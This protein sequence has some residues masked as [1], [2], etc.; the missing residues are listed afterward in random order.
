MSPYTAPSTNASLFRTF[1][2]PPTAVTFNERPRAVGRGGG[3]LNTPSRAPST[4]STPERMPPSMS[5]LDDT[6][7]STSMLPVHSRSTPASVAHTPTS[8]ASTAGLEPRVNVFGF[9]P[10]HEARVLREIRRHGDVV[11]FEVER[12]NWTHAMY[13]TQVSAQVLLYRRGHYLPGNTV[14]FG[15]VSFTEPEIACKG[16]RKVVSTRFHWVRNPVFESAPKLD[17]NVRL[18]LIVHWYGR[19]KYLA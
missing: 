6:G 9:Q 8:I 14:M 10:S 11:R 12:G 2:S 1:A 3:A 4:L 19:L 15:I 7:T 13:G 16:E 5:L 18:Q 17:V